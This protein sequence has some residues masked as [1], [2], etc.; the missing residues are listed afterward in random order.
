MSD[1]QTPEWCCDY[2]VSLLDV[3]VMDNKKV[4][5]PTPGDDGSIDYGSSGF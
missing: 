1:F 3:H 4:L 2:M 5:E